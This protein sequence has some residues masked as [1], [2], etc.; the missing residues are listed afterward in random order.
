M[1]YPK[2][3]IFSQHWLDIIFEGRNKQYGAYVLRRNASK[4][5]NLAL[6]IASSVF[7]VSLLGPLIKNRFSPDAASQVLDQPL[8]PGVIV[9]LTPPPPIDKSLSQPPAA[10]PPAPRTSQVRMSAPVVVRADQVTEEP[11]SIATLKLANP[12]SQTLAGNPDAAIHI[13]VPLGDGHGDVAVTE[14]GGQSDVPFTAVEIEPSFPGGMEAF[15]KY[16]QENY[17]YPPQAMEHGVKGKI[18]LAFIVE[19]DGSLTDITIMRDLK[20]G[21]GEEAV[22][23][24]TTS[25]KWTPGIQNGRPVRVAYTLPIGLDISH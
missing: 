19:R 24:L 17:R 5:T 23:L 14:T 16:V 7:V 2:Q 13:D 25:P 15:L 10:A 3:D 20:F 12:G 18:I 1:W 6:C 4:N 11:P 22:R 9:E 8:K 21:T